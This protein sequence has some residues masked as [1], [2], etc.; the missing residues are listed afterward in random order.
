[1]RRRC[2]QAYRKLTE[3]IAELDE[4]G[5]FDSATDAHLCLDLVRE[6]LLQNKAAK[7]PFAMPAVKGEKLAA[8]TMPVGFK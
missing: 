6:T 1:M 2:D 5:L 8:F 3:A 4:C 7:A